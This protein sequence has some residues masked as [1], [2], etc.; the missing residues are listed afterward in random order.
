MDDLYAYK[1]EIG[2]KAP[3]SARI[4][5]GYTQVLRA[6]EVG[7]S[8]L[9]PTSANSLRALCGAIEAERRTKGMFLAR[10]EGDGARAWRVK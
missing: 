3:S 6:L 1:R 4:G 5:K 9:L 7:E 8:V 2:V 10:A